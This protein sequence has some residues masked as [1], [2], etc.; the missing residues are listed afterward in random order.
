M[1]RIISNRAGNHDDDMR[2]SDFEFCNVPGCTEFAQ[3]AD[4]T[5]KDT[6]LV[7]CA[8]HAA[9]AT[10]AGDTGE[11]AP[12]PPEFRIFTLQDGHNR[13]RIAEPSKEGPHG[14]SSTP[15]QLHVVPDRDDPDGAGPGHAGGEAGDRP[16]VRV[17]PLR[18]HHA[19]GPGLAAAGPDAPR[20]DQSQDAAGLAA[21]D[22]DAAAGDDAPAAPDEARPLPVIGAKV[23]GDHSGDANE[24]G[25]ELREQTAGDVS[26]AKPKH[27][28]KRKAVMPKGMP[29]CPVKN[30]DTGEIYPSAKIAAE[31]I[32]RSASG[33]TTAI[34]NGIKCAGHAWAWADKDDV[35]A[36]A[37]RSRAAMNAGV[38]N[39]G[40]GTR[41]Q[42]E[43]AIDRAPKPSDALVAAE[44]ESLPGRVLDGI[45]RTMLGSGIRGLSIDDFSLA[46]T[47]GGRRTQISLKEFRISVTEVAS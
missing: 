11:R 40:S 42:T 32:G 24:M 17:R 41:L 28:T 22:P 14:E 7:K 38:E 13:H 4:P 21:G 43:S 46:V 20:A 23:G 5:V 35:L 1:A 37:A 26:P 33:I 15:Q 34:A 9:A 12:L 10:A 19:D 25:G 29:P 39:T 6:R 30:L 31:K 44:A 45:T 18:T 2:S 8:K 27:P 36:A 47:A 3:T 16:A